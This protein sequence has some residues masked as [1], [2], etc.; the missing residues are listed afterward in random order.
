MKVTWK[1]FQRKK[2]EMKRIWHK[3]YKQVPQTKLQMILNNFFI[4]PYPKFNSSLSITARS[5]IKGF[6]A[7]YDTIYI[8]TIYKNFFFNFSPVQICNIF[9]A[10]VIAYGTLFEYDIFIR[11][12]IKYSFFFLHKLLFIFSTT[13]YRGICLFIQP[14]L[15]FDSK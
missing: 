9:C 5:E 2:V 1:N 6:Q 12:A 13:L 7:G 4:T 14:V 3:F 11:F 10:L 8:K 15:T